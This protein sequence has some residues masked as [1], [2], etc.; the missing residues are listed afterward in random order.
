MTSEGARKH[1]ILFG[2]HR[3]H[4]N[5]H[6][7]SHQDR[8]VKLNDK[9]RIQLLLLATM[10]KNKNFKSFSQLVES[11]CSNKKRKFQ[12]I[13]LLLKEL[14]EL[15]KAFD[16]NDF[17][18]AVLNVA[19]ENQISYQLYQIW[20]QFCR[21][22]EVFTKRIKLLCDNGANPNKII[23]NGL[24]RYN[25][26]LLMTAYDRNFSNFQFICECSKY[27]IDINIQ[28]VNRMT[29][30][31]C[32]T[33]NNF[34]DISKLINIKDDGLSG[35]ANVVNDDFIP[36]GSTCTRLWYATKDN[37]LAIVE[38]LCESNCD[39]N[40]KCGESDLSPLHYVYCV[41]F[42]V[43]ESKCN[44]NL[45]IKHGLTLATAMKAENSSQILKILCNNRE[46]KIECI[47]TVIPS[48]SDSNSSNKII[49]IDIFEYVTTYCPKDQF[50]LFFQS[51]LNRENINDGIH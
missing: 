30:L 22:Q 3:A 42:L 19:N 39:I 25:T 38:L 11:V 47:R 6:L 29:A 21:M 44:V 43:E 46:V 33:L 13:P 35:A 8:C 14:K 36:C 1:L 32:A 16:E 40:I 34:S 23:P 37:N 48:D 41:N 24:N 27:D 26:I 51:I 12:T 49:N 45:K 9:R 17:Y 28:D 20:D 10:K 2:G 5:V 18:C 15:S 4:L 31:H 7:P 50:K